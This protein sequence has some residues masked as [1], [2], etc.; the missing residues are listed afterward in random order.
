MKGPDKYLALVRE[1]VNSSV[2]DEPPG[3]PSEDAVAAKLE[4]QLAEWDNVDLIFGLSL[5][6]SLHRVMTG[7][8]NRR[9]KEARG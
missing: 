3:D 6:F 9:I 8:A 4:R 7:E 1:L 2:G 5:T